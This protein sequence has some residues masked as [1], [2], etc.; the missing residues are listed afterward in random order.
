VE[1]EFQAVKIL[2]ETGKFDNEIDIDEKKSDEAS[3]NQE[4]E[5]S[6]NINNINCSFRKMKMNK[7]H[8]K[9]AH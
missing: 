2:L 7:H 5:K 3:K 4:N 6:R 1:K 9:T 8:S